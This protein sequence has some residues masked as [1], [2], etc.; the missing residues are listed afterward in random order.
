MTTLIVFFIILSIL[1]LVHEL[2]HFIAARKCGVLVEEFGLGIPPRL[3]G[4]KFGETLYSVNVFPFGGFVKLFGEDP[5]ELSPEVK[6]H[7][8][9]FLSKSPLQRIVILGA[10]V[11][12]NLVMALFLYTVLFV[13]TNY[14]SLTVPV[15]FGYQFRYGEVTHLDTVITGFSENSPAKLVGLETGEA[16]LEI[17]GRQVTSV[18]DIRQVVNADSIESVLVLV[19]DLRYNVGDHERLVTIPTVLN[20]DGVRVLGIYVGN[21]A[22]ITYKSKLLAPIQHSYNM[23]A[24]TMSTFK[25]FI[26]MA[27]VQKSV[28]P[29]SSGVTGPVG[30]YS[31][32]GSILDFGGIEAFVSLIDFMALLSLSLAFLNFLPLPALDGG[33]LL[34]VGYELI[35]KKP[36]DQKIEARIHKL[37]LLFFMLLLFMVTIKDVKNL[38]LL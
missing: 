35:F 28:E 11:V 10:G 17:N 33:R 13:F 14:K 5:E 31:V 22:Y 15:F 32:V 1:I 18:E 29:V 12:M 23:M 26:K 30:I 20:E 3:F 34:F 2:G 27:L 4:K 24:Y 19:R 38:F 8:R 9:S 36:V 6:T 7:P 21:A 25:E 37:G 16:V